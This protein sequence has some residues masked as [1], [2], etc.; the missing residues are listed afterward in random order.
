MSLL[1]RLHTYRASAG[2]SPTEDFL[3]ETFAEWLR[4]AGAAGLTLLARVSV[5]C[6]GSTG[7]SHV[8]VSHASVD[9]PVTGS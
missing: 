7:A 1:T 2:R 5:F 4:L 8:L 9:S 6:G 3:S